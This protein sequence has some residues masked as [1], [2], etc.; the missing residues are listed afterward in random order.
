MVIDALRGSIF[1]SAVNLPFEG[2]AESES[3]SLIH[4]AERLGSFAGQLVRGRV[5]DVTLELWGADEKLRNILAVASAKGLLQPILKETVNYVNAQSVAEQRG[6]DF[7]T[8]VHQSPQ[9]YTHL[10]ALKVETDAESMTVSGTVFGEK[11]ARIVEVNG[12]RVEF[13]PDGYL[14]YM[15]NRDVPGVIG[16]VGTIL[17]DREINI[18]EYNL[19][20]VSGGGHAMAIVTVDSRLDEETLGF[21]RSF[22]EMEDVRQI[23]L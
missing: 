11:I 22:K 15:V 17:G 13:E 14:L 20:R 19:A 12:F 16:K 10:L 23:K 5:S 18:A 9:D 2:L 7:A 21:L 1:V 6:I 3:S 8:T 4:L